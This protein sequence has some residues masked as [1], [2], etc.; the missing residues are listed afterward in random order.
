MGT[1]HSR[2]RPGKTDH[3]Y[4]TETVGLLVAIGLLLA[5]VG[6]LICWGTM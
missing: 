1:H 2:S 4:D 6:A 5:S 3:R